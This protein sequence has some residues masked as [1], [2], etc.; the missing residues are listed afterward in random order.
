VFVYIKE[1]HPDDGWKVPKNK[2]DGISV[3]QP[4]S[5]TER[6][7]VAKSCSGELKLTMPVIV[8]SMDNKTAQDYAAWPDRLY[9]VGTDG[10]IAYK[11]G[12][13]PGGFKAKEMEAKLK[14]VLAGK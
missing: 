10:K 5:L 6:E 12:P 1:A 7:G 14:D 2:K 11:G 3:D 9:I 8:D 13:G 4:K